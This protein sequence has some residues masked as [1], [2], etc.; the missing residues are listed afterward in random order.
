MMDRS[1]EFM[2]ARR[3]ITITLGDSKSCQ[4]WEPRWEKTF[5]EFAEKLSVA[6]R[7]RK[8]GPAY[9]PAIL[10]GVARQLPFVERI[11]IA[12]LDSDAGYTLDEISYAVDKAGCE[13]LIHSTHSHLT[14]RAEVSLASLD[15]C[16][17]DLEAVMRGKG[18]LPRVVLGCQKIGK[19]ADG[20]RAIIGH[21]PCPKYRIIIPLLEP[22]RVADY[23]SPAAAHEAWRLFY[24]GLAE[25]LGL[26]VDLSCSDPSRFFFLPRTRA[27]GPDYEFRRVRGNPVDFHAAVGVGASARRKPRVPPPVRLL[28]WAATHASRFEIG[29]ALKA[30]RPDKLRRLN[31]VK[32]VVECPFEH[33]HTE[34]GGEGTF[35]VNAS[36]VPAAGLTQ[37]HSGFFLHC[38]HNACAHRDRL[39]LLAGVLERGWLSEG[40]LTD[41]AFLARGGDAAPGDG[42]QDGVRL[43]DFRAYMPMHNYIFA[44]AGDM[45]PAS[46]VNS[47]VPPVLLPGPGAKKISASAWLDKHRPVEQMTWAPGKPKLIENLMMADGAWISREGVTCFNLYRP[48]A[49]KTAMPGMPRGGSASSARFT[50]PKPVTSFDGLRIAFSTQR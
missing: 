23:P 26:R 4:I 10:K 17:G 45:W 34:P 28:P 19:T 36:Q 9:T 25:Q 11:D 20:K 50:G 18:F 43:E 48:P 29:S 39:A 3:I 44:A 24:H 38:S 46:S 21:L 31:G 13:A 12:V 32:Q 30:K 49:K 1:A 7:G 27:G 2:A 6:P 41:P 16:G 8:D 15:Q 42:F 35:A 14:D 22:W 47:R 33:E 37:I 5:D 40:D